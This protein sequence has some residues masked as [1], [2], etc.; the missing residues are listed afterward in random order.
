MP[1]MER[2]SSLYPVSIRTLKTELTDFLTLF[3]L[4]ITAFELTQSITANVK[5][6]WPS[7]V[8]ADLSLTTMQNPRI[9]HRHDFDYFAGRSVKILLALG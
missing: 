8:N 4:D 5:N 3:S 2:Y 6:T 1:K 7:S 9:L